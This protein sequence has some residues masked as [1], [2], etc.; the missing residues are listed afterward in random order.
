MT[1]KNENIYDHLCKTQ[2]RLINGVFSCHE[3]HTDVQ[4]LDLSSA[5]FGVKKNKK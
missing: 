1:E 3:K 2:V 4:P 5:H